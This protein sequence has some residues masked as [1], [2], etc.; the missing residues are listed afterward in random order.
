[1]WY[2]RYSWLSSYNGYRK[3]VWFFRS[4]FSIKCLK[5]IWFGENFIYWIELLSTSYF[6]LGKGAR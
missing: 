5:E 4:W 6:I 3:S 1:M 2:T